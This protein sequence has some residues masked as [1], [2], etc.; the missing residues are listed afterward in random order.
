[1]N[2]VDVGSLTATDLISV[3]NGCGRGPVLS[4]YL[5]KN[6]REKAGTSI[7]GSRLLNLPAYIGWLHSQHRSRIGNTVADKYESHKAKMAEVSRLKSLATREIGEIPEPKWS[8]ERE[9]CRFDLALFCKTFLPGWFSKDFCDQQLEAIGEIQQIVL[10]GGQHAMAL[11]RHRGK[12]TI[13]KAACLWAVLYGHRKYVVWLA[14]Q[15]EMADPAIDGF[16]MMLRTN[17]KM[18]EAFPKVCCPLV[19]GGA[20][21]RS[22]PLY[23]GQELHM[24]RS[25]L[26]IILPDI[27]GS[28][29]ASAVLEAGGLMT[30]V[31]GLTYDRPDGTIARPDLVVLDDPQTDDSANSAPQCDKREST[32]NQA[33]LGLAGPGIRLAAVMPCTIIRHGD[34]S[35]RIL[36]RKLNPEWHGVIGKALESMPERMDL[37]DQYNSIRVASLNRDNTIGPATEFYLKHRAEM[38]RGT[39]ATWEEDFRPGEVSAIQHCMNEYYRDRDYF[40]AEMQNSPLQALDLVRQLQR[41]ELIERTNFMPRG[42]APDDTEVTTAFVDVHQ[43]IQYWMVCAWRQNFSGQ[44]MAYG[45]FPDQKSSYFDQRNVDF[46]M[47]AVKGYRGKSLETQIEMAL[48]EIFQAIDV[49]WT[50]ESGQVARLRMGLVDA[51]WHKSTAVVHKFAATSA[52]RGKIFGSHGRGIS[53][54][55]KPIEAWRKEKKDVFGPD[56]TIPWDRGDHP[57]RHVVFDANVWKN[58][59]AEFLMADADGAASLALHHPEQQYDHRLLVDHFVSETREPKIGPFRTV[60]IWDLPSNRP[61]NHWFDCLV[62]CAVAAS[63][64]GI[65]IPQ[66]VAAR[67]LPVKKK[68]RKSRVHYVE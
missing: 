20:D 58:H 31:R 18:I 49:E 16:W 12:T 5:L 56:W 34:L 9:A 64:C 46:K 8:E 23:K 13:T 48:I 43:D 68:P 25:G 37:W 15:D 47:G 45:T 59:V 39:A 11:P 22:R 60:D 62:G 2:G 52:W 51:N 29:A 6:H 38:D 19:K 53:A 33:V 61:D 50:T 42:I 63:I 40:F 1:M 55:Q 32:I 10:H 27:E 65:R 7:G 24:G 41:D 36:N 14:A 17:Q 57:W 26:Q 4:R 54:A 21:Q 44:I 67:A 66:L 30:A 35:S 28:E 3:M